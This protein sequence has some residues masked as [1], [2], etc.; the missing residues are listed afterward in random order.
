MELKEF[1]LIKTRAGNR[2]GVDLG[3]FFGADENDLSMLKKVRD[4]IER[5]LDGYNNGLPIDEIDE[6]LEGFNGYFSY[7]VFSFKLI[8]HEEL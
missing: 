4:Y 6:L 5:W 2:T 3:S 1:R 8:E 7:D